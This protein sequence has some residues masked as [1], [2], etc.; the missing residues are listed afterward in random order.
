MINDYPHDWR[1]PEPEPAQAVLEAAMD[2]VAV[3][4]AAGSLVAFVAW[5][6]SG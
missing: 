1:E 5:V 3:L 4:L 2:V 6:L